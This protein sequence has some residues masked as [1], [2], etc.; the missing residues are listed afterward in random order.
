M[1]LIEVGSL[2]PDFS[3][4]DQAGKHRA[5]KD[6]RGRM[7][8]L[9]FY[10]E[11]DTPLCTGQACQFRDHHPD[12]T[13]V[14]AVVLGV[15]PQD[16]ASKEMFAE[17]HA[18]PFILLADDAALFG[19]VVRAAPRQDGHHGGEQSEDRASGLGRE[20]FHAPTVRPRHAARQPREAALTWVK[21]PAA[22]R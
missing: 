19:G 6:F 22:S 18:L 12:F 15:S 9:Y 16:V 5:L 1:P 8:V 4:K 3:L 13:K 11:D 14:K 21:G 7:V 17:K 2:A 10:P 20:A